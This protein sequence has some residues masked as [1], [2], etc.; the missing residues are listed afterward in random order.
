M[1]TVRCAIC[2]RKSSDEGL[3]QSFNSLDAQ[4]EACAA[5]ILSQASEGWTEVK[6][7]YDDGGLSGGTLQRPALQRLLADI[8]QGRVDIVVVYKVYRLTRSLLDFAKLVEVFDK[9]G[10]NFVSITQS[11]NTT[12]SMGRLTLNMLLSFA[13]FE[14]EVTAERIRDKIAA[15]KAKGMW[16]GGVPPIGYRPDGRSLA[17]VDEHAAFVRHVFARYLALRNVRHVIDE[18][19]RDG[20]SAPQRVLT[21]GREIGGGPLTRGQLYKMLNCVTYVGEV[22]HRGA[23]YA[24]NHPAI[25]DRAT[26]DAMQALLADNLQ[27]RRTARNVREPSLLA[28][29][30]V[31][32][33]GEPLIATHACKGSVRYRHYVSNG[34]KDGACS[35]L[36]VPA[37]ELEGLVSRQ[38]AEAFDDPMALAAAAGSIVDAS[39]L[40]DALGKGERA[41]LAMR[42]KQR[43]VIRALIDRVIIDN[44][45]VEVR[46]ANAVLAQLGLPTSAQADAIVSMSCAARMTRTGRVVRLVQ[47]DGALSVPAV[48]ST[49]IQLI[50]NSVAEIGGFCRIDAATSCSAD[51]RC[52]ANREVARSKG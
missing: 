4:R 24:G 50:A 51:L 20:R 42:Q 9:A 33:G 34:P 31:D 1:K 25:I 37:A 41:A 12:A 45:R 52:L 22:A 3:E 44:G 38:L 15:S 18:L 16:M 39:R 26:W 5:Y 29:R 8:A 46:R 19:C 48:D 11:F 21:N 35:A 30:V 6:E 27:G 10:V 47:A 40:N 13:Q 14:R 28:R 36:R 49:L 32:G 2:T 23:T 17:I 43:E 7:Q